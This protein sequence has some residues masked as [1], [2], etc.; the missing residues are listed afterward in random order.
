MGGAVQITLVDADNYIELNPVRASMVA[1]AS[2]YPWSSYQ[3]NAMGKAIEL[4]TPHLIYQQ[5]GRAN[6]ERHGAYRALFRGRMPE[7]DL[8]AIREAT[9]KAWVLGD[10]SWPFHS[11][12]PLAYN[13]SKAALNMFTVLLA[14]ELR[15]EG[16]RV[17]SVS[18][19]WIA[20]DLGGSSAPGTPEEGA[21]IALKCAL[22]GPDGPTGMFLT[23]GGVIPW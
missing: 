15:D 13:S 1:H 3:C 21:A 23:A 4:L 6:T 7:R 18:P 10:P 12:T 17:N 14:K 16:F 19:G 11:T 9:N 5:L 2:E 8:A 20:T 22:E